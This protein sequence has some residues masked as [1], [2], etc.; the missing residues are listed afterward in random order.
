MLRTELVVNTPAKTNIL[1]RLEEAFVNCERFYVN[2]AF[3]NFSG[4][5]LL[6]DTLK[7]AEQNNI[8]GQVITST[9]LNFTD[10][11]S[12]EKLN[13]F[14][15]IDMRVFVP[16]KQRGFHPKAFIFEYA[17]TIRV[18]IG[19]ANIT[20]SA[21]KSNVE[22]TVSTLNKH[23][24]D[25][26]KSVY[27]EFHTLWQAS[28]PV[29]D[30][31]INEYQQF[32]ATLKPS[33]QKRDLFQLDNTIKP[34]SMQLTAMQNLT[35]LRKEQHNKALIVAATGSGKTYLA[36]FDVQQVQPKKCLFVVHSTKILKDAKASFEKIIPNANTGLLDG[37]HKDVNAD[38]LFATNLS[39]LNQLSKFSPDHFDYIII[40]EA[41]HV[42][43]SSYK[44]ILEHFSPQFLL[45][46][47]ATPE[48]IDVAD[49]YEVFDHNVAVD[50][51]LRDALEQDLVVPFHYFGVVEAATIDYQHI[52]MNKPEELARLL[53][54]HYRVEHII[55]Q[56]DFY[57]FDGDKLQAI[58]FC[59]DVDHAKYMA[60][61]FSE[62][63]IPAL[64]LSGNDPQHTREKAIDELQSTQHSL[65]IIFTVDIFNEGVDIPAINTVLM[66]RPTQSPII[67]IQQL[68]RGLRK[69]FDKEFL[70]VIDFIG[71]HNNAFLIA[72][73]LFGNR[74]Y[75]KDSLKVAV[76]TDFISLPGCSHI[77]L[78]EIIKE[79]ILAQIDNE[80]FNRLKYLKEEYLAFK[81]TVGRHVPWLMD[82]FLVD[83]APDPIK[84]IRNYK[85]Y[86]DF[87]VK[88][89]K[90]NTELLRLN[91][92]NVFTSLYRFFSD[93]LPVVRIHEFVL[94]KYLLQ[95]KSIKAT[96]AQKL[97]SKWIPDISMDDVYHA[98]K[99]LEGAYFDTNDTKKYPNFGVLK[100]QS[101]NIATTDYLQAAENTD[102]FF[103]SSKL[104]TCCQD[105]QKK[106]LDD[107]ISYGIKTY[108]QNFAH[109]HLSAPFLLPYC[110]YNMRQTALA[111]QYQ[112]KHSAFR[113]QGVFRKDNDFFLFIELHKSEG[114]IE[115]QDK[116]TSIDTLQ[117]QSPRSSRQDS[118]QGKQII[119]HK[120][121][122]YNLHIFVRKFK[123]IDNLVQPYIYLGT[124]DVTEYQ[125]NAPIT[126][127]MTLHQPIR[128][129]VYLEFT[130]N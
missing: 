116:I 48:R 121:Q 78:D 108:E 111:I 100:S 35:D 117:W 33:T 46:M 86:L 14:S 54:N 58:G 68:G 122:G 55:E 93:H 74:Y 6:L 62:M 26:V 76:K 125:D 115:Y 24:T 31:F 127:Q 83:G 52:D 77:K 113:G 7:T 42:V 9:Y 51:R 25:F 88:I 37:Q 104:T 80:N 47:T 16:T 73:A 99:Y 69:H 20:Q 19:S 90:S 44:S 106:W 95:H 96:Y 67:F 79:Q 30:R 2:V 32:L 110:Q 11:K 12:I 15:N 126:M 129:D 64:A 94:L 128:N 118:G 29:T 13:A 92:D 72:V 41:H 75:D 63:G 59:V 39:L 10:P 34:N 98:L 130:V 112:K 124:A 87:L 4:L 53:K 1:A 85:T 3:V 50:I 27:A 38:Y 81:Q 123:E 70:T 102:E 103:L 114:A 28:E 101:A 91:S 97:L 65:N 36:A 60:K 49:V 57:G 82:Y 22:W 105:Q 21:L 71:N 45:G 119:E 5:Q 8:P 23:N 107:I 40:D 61:E 43:S 120:E 66:L 89:E 109:A 84:F 17:D 18:F 56:I